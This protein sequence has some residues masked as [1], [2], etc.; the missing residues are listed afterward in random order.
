MHFFGNTFLDEQELMVLLA[1]PDRHSWTGRRDKVFF[2]LAAECGMRVSEII[3]LDIGDLHLG[4]GTHISCVGK[5]RKMRITPIAAQMVSLLNQWLKER[6]GTTDIYL[7]ADMAQLDR[8]C[9]F[10][11]LEEQ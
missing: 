5:G 3:N 10:G 4:S 6:G 2:T 9:I 1:A 11:R 8:T 7:H